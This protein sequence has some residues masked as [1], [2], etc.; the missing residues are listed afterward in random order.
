MENLL[1]YDLETNGLD[2]DTTYIMQITVADNYRNILWNK[3][4]YPLDGKIYGVEVHHIDEDVLQRN[5]A[6]TLRDCCYDML[7]IINAL[8][9]NNPVIWIAY[10]NFGYDQVILEKNFEKVGMSIPKN[11]YFRD[12]LPIIRHI[13][14]HTLPN[15]KLG[16]VFSILCDRNIEGTLHNSLT[17]VYCLYDIYEYIKKNHSD[18]YYLMVNKYTRYS[19]RDKRILNCSFD[20]F[21][22]I[23]SKK[24]FEKKGFYK[25]NDIYQK[26]KEFK[27]DNQIFDLYLTRNIGIYSQYNKSNFIKQMQIMSQSL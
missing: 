4:C 3:Y 8:Y 10:N 15:Y 19:L 17:D 23:N 5:N 20:V 13:Y 12:L 7:K 24:L 6:M 14:P 21:L 25:V 16:T 26:Y 22:D 2:Y 18:I 9:E 11:W 27:F 1:F